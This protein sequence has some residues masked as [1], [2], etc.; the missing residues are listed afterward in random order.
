[1]KEF[2]EQTSSVIPFELKAIFEEILNLEVLWMLLTCEQRPRNGQWLLD[3]ITRTD[4]ILLFVE[5]LERTILT[6]KACVAF[7]WNLAPEQQFTFQ[8]S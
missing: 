2:E 1:M 3:I 6:P 4:Q 7:E 5:L 8:T